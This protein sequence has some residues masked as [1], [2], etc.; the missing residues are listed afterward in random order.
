MTAIAFPVKYLT[1]FINIRIDSPRFLYRVLAVRRGEAVHTTMECVS[2]QPVLIY[3]LPYCQVVPIFAA[4]RPLNGVMDAIT[5]NDL[6]AYEGCEIA[7][8]INPGELK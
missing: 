7:S 5:G 3:E 8:G 4:L 2:I 1:E 6:L